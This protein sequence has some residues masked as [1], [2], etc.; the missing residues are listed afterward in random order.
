MV[1][2]AF[3][4]NPTDR[5]RMF[6]MYCVD[7]GIDGCT[8]LQNPTWPSS[9]RLATYEKL[10]ALIVMDHW[11]LT[12]FNFIRNRVANATDNKIADE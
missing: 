8:A 10:S 3:V 4:D 2:F 9:N 6:F 5:E 12:G 1:W 11:R 7:S